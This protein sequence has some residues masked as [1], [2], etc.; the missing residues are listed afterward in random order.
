MKYVIDAS[1]ALKWFL[2][3]AGKEQ[4]LA[5]AAAVGEAIQARGAELFAPPHWVTE[6]IAVL[7]RKEPQLLD[8]ALLL[9]GECNPVIVATANVLKHGADISIKL[10]HH[11]FDALYHAVALETGATLVTADDVYFGKAKALG[12]IKMLG[13]FAV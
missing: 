12:Q 2:N 7:A 3:D 6:V 11:L 13:E 9:L 1:V 4:N 10:N 5:E 8:D